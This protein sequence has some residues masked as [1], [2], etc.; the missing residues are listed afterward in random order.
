MDTLLQ[1]QDAGFAYN[2]V[3]ALTGVGLKLA[4][5]EVVAI[6][7]PNGS[8]KT[9][10]LKLLMGQLHG[11]GEIRWKNQ[12]VSAWRRRDL[13]R[14]VAY[15]P[16][17]PLWDAAQ[18]VLDALRLGRAP[19]WGPLGLESSADEQIVRGVTQT[20]GLEDL[21]RRRMDELSGGQ[22][23]RVLLGRCLAQQ[24]AAMLLDEPDTF[25]D[26]KHQLEMSRLLRSLATERKMAVLVASHD[27]N[28]AATFADRIVLLRDGKLAA[29]GTPKEVLQP[30]ILGEVYGVAMERIERAGKPAAV[31]P[32]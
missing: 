17:T 24:P 15:L 20:L 27:L 21:L 22:R 31:V 9:T 8:G 32:G 5:G 19:Y 29:M 10:L 4:A 26:L 11:G 28:L 16:Q 30:G 7:G 1:V 18:T 12:L 23:Q 6:L 14:L 2:S 3:A 25:L 13:A